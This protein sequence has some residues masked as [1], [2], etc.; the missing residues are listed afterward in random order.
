MD[1]SN[2]RSPALDEVFSPRGIAV[3]GASGSGKMGF[4]EMNIMALLEAEYPAIYPVNQKY[5]SVL[6]LKCYPSILNIPGPVDHLIVS[7]PAD[8]V[9]ELLDQCA[10]KKVK[11]VHFFTAGFGESGLKERADLEKTMLEKARQGGFRI[12]GPNCVG[13]FVP[14]NRVVNTLSVPLEPGPVSFISQSGGHASTLPM[15]SATRGLRYSKVVSYG[16]ALD[17][18]EIELLDYL[19]HDSETKIISAY[20]EGIRDGHRFRQA[21]EKAAQAKPVVIYKGGRT[22]AG[23]R[24]AHSHTASLTSSVAVFESLCHQMNSI[25][26]DNMDELIDVLVTLNFVNPLPAGHRLALVGAGGGPSVLA[27]DEMETAG[28]EM[29]RFSDKLQD[30]LKKVLPF[31]GSIFSNPLDTSNMTAPSAIEAALDILGRSDEVD[32]IVYHLGFHAIGMWGRGRFS[33]TE[34]LNT[35]TDILEKARRNYH[36]P[37]LLALRPAQNREGMSEFLAAQEAFVKAGFPV[38]YSLGGLALALKRVLDWHARG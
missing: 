1:K 35:V 29:P 15:F 23:L 2:H 19:T 12:V 4:A 28:L 21:L 38:Y 10:Q 14:K 27:G 31:D 8:S 6:G 24:A 16:N 7:I 34:Y 13:L 5:S 26:V 36:K 9:L 18:D 22:E 3:I 11:S 32:L 30:N 25:L 37:V 20:L 33:S 17:I